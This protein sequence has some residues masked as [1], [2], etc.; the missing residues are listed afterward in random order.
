[1][2]KPDLRE[3]ERVLY[4]ANAKMINFLDSDDNRAVDKE[5]LKEL[6]YLQEDIGFS[7]VDCFSKSRVRR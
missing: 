4:D 2:S 1:M 7:G 3:I 6:R 5:L